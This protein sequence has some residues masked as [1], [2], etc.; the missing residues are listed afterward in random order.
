MATGRYDKKV[1]IQAEIDEEGFEKSLEKMGREVD[2]FAK[3]AT[4]GFNEVTKASE[5][6]SSAVKAVAD[7]FVDSKI[8]NF[9]Q[10][11]AQAADNYGKWAAAC[12]DL[13]S[14]SGASANA[15]LD[16]ANKELA[17]EKERQRILALTDQQRHSANATAATIANENAKRGMFALAQAEKVA[18]A[19]EKVAT[20]TL[21]VDAA[22]T[23]ATLSARAM[24]AARAGAGALAKG[25]QGLIATLGGPFMAAI[26]AA[27]AA[28]YIFSSR[29]TES[30][31]IAAKY[32]STI[33]DLGGSSEDSAR[34]VKELEEKILSLSSQRAKLELP[35]YRSSL[36]RGNSRA[37]RWGQ[38]HLSG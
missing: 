13:T 14:A 22:Q 7:A 29:Q 20:A 36:R 3:S 1:L 16:A 12:K 24:S 23:K 28:V 33:A 5:A 11:V 18:I 15:I 27:S 25:F 30:E 34:A 21:A 2:D 19:E 37:G 31:K 8:S 35:D 6:L 4:T 26:T 17:V 9:S 38:E 10:E 32:S